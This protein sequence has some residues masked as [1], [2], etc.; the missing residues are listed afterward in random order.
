MWKFIMVVLTWVAVSGLAM[1]AEI[2]HTV[3]MA[4]KPSAPLWSRTG[5]HI[6]GHVGGI[7]SQSKDWTPRTPGGDHYGESLGS[8]DAESWLGGLQ[9]GCDYQFTQGF[10]IGIQGD[11]AWANAESSHDST[12]ETGVAYHSTVKSLATVTGRLGYAFDRLLG[13]VRGGVAWQRD[14]LWATTTMLG[15]AYEYSPTRPGWTI[16]VGAEYTFNR[17]LSS[18]VEYGYYNFTASNLEFTPQVAGLSKA[19]VDITQI[20]N[21]FRIGVNYR[22]GGSAAPITKQ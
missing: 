10:V 7:R 1:A 11:Y 21:V 2:D 12:R 18:F 19:F 13:Y 3:G 6:G 16:G 14:D 5:C 4:S 9:V 17:S 15:T 22:F 8:H 20:T